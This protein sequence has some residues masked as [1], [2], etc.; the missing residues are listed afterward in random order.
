M[1]LWL[2]SGLSHRHPQTPALN[3]EFIYKS[4]GNYDFD[5]NLT[6]INKLNWLDSN[7]L[8]HLLTKSNPFRA[9]SFETLQNNPSQFLL[10]QYPA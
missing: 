10:K 2:S 6:T 3:L 7:V 5:Y 1:K 4:D 9:S 8:A